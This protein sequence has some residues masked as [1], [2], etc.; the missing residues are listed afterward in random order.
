M[1]E[2]A[3]AMHIPQEQQRE[4]VIRLHLLT[5][6]QALAVALEQFMEPRGTGLLVAH[7]RDAT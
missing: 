5:K 6:N 1:D 2:V 3:L 7:Q 4:S